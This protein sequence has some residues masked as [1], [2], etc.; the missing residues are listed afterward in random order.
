MVRLKRNHIFAS[1]LVDI[2]GQ[3]YNSLG[4]YFNSYYLNSR[5]EENS[6]VSVING[7]IQKKLQF[8]GA[9]SLNDSRFSFELY[10]YL[11]NFFLKKVILFR[12]IF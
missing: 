8:R 10:I 4:F 9:S 5:D 7:S 6:S 3:K 2:N 12:Y 1:P 11:D